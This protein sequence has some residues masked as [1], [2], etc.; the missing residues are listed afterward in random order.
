MKNSF[1]KL[2]M[3]EEDYNNFQKICESKG[4]PMSKVIRSF[5]TAYNNSQN[6]I[7]LDV[8]NDTLKESIELC[9]EK[10]IKFNDLIKFLLNDAIKNKDELKI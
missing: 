7:L 1:L 9:K 2:R 10:K 4:K 6:I 5:I 3:T 8:D